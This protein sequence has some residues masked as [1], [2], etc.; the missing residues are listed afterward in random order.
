[1]QPFQVICIDDKDRPNEV[2]ISRWVKEGELYTVI[3]MNKMNQ[4]GKMLAFK[5]E[6]LNNDDLFPYTHFKASRF[7][8]FVGIKEGDLNEISQEIANFV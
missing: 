1:M 4:Q 8:V 7:A 2:P 3:A 5:L 6:E